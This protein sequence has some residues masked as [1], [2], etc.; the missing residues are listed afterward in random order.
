VLSCKVGGSY[1][2]VRHTWPMVYRKFPSKCLEMVRC[3]TWFV[4]YVPCSFIFPFKVRISHD[5]C[6]SKI[7]GLFLMTDSQQITKELDTPYLLEHLQLF[8]ELQ[9][10]R[11]LACNFLAYLQQLHSQSCNNYILAS[12]LATFQGAVKAFQFI[13]G[14][15]S[16]HVTLLRFSLSNQNFPQSSLHLGKVYTLAS[17]ACSSP[18]FYASSNTALPSTVQTAAMSQEQPYLILQQQQ[19]SMVGHDSS[20]TNPFGN[21]YEDKK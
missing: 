20:S 12:L 4:L 11:L 8:K 15:I 5:S 19:S 17:W 7:L 13:K 6:S 21:P 1:Y 16:I 9:L 14:W 2:S 18:P 3:L 10:S